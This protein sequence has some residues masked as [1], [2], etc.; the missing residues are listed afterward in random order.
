MVAKPEILNTHFSTKK[1]NSNEFAVKTR[2]KKTDKESIADDPGRISRPGRD[3]AR[4]VQV[5]DCTHAM[6]ARWSFWTKIHIVGTDWPRFASKSHRDS[7]LG[8]AC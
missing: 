4:H 1:T 8:R 5:K 2:G 3:I 6:S 7:N